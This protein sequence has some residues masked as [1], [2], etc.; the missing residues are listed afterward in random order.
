MRYGVVSDVHGNLHAL[1]TALAALDRAGAERILCPGDL[2][3]YGPRPNE[4]V[5]RLRAAGAAAVAGNHDLMAVG[6]LEQRRLGRLVSTTIEWTRGELDAET[7]A[8]LESLP[9]RVTTD[10]GVTIAHGSLDDPTEYVRDCVR[11]MAELGALS[12]R[13]P[14]AAG[15]LLGHTHHPLAC[16]RSGPLPAH[17]LLA[18]E[19]AGSPWLLNAGSVGQSRERLPLA[20]ALVLD[21]GAGQA[22]FLALDYDVAATRRELRDAGLPPEA[23]HLKPGRAARLVRNMRLRAR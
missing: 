2:V 20:R 7:R 8:Y 23:C 14:R 19:D 16:G 17:G 3:G 1:D 9:E 12:E 10:D 22:E 11:G 6:R 15:L 5:A 4:C 21:T 13:E 18:L